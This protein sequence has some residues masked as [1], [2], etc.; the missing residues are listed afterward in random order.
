MRSLCGFV[1]LVLCA[2]FLYHAAGSLE[3]VDHDF[4][5]FPSVNMTLLFFSDQAVPA[6]LPKH[7]SVVENRALKIRPTAI[8][9]MPTARHFVFVVDNSGTMRHFQSLLK[10]MVHALSHLITRHDVYSCYLFSDQ[11]HTVCELAKQGDNRLERLEGLDFSGRKTY[12]YDSLYEILSH[13]LNYDNRVTVCLCLTD[14]IDEGSITTANDIVH[15]IN[16][17]NIKFIP[18]GFGAKQ[19]LDEL[20]RVS[21]ISGCQGFKLGDEQ[22]IM[23][24]TEYVTNRFSHFY[25]MLYL[26]RVT[27]PGPY[28]VS[29][30]VTAGDLSIHKTFKTAIPAALLPQ[31]SSAVAPAQTKAAPVKKARK[32][33]GSYLYYLFA[34]F[35]LIFAVVL[36]VLLSRRRQRNRAVA[37]PLEDDKIV[38]AEAEESRDVSAT[39]MMAAIPEL[40]DEVI[41]D[42]FDEDALGKTIVMS[43]EPV[44]TV[45]QGSSRKITYNLSGKEHFSIGR[46][47][48]NDIVLANRSVSAR[49]ALIRNISG[50]YVIY[51][52]KSTNGTF[53]NGQ[54]INKA[55]LKPGDSIHAGESIL[56]FQLRRQ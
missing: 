33:F 48:G 15:L 20:L 31:K 17:H 51:D 42:D 30:Q 16:T 5:A 44:I 52:L 7:V 4:S 37:L 32:S 24:L 9:R 19:S 8:T 38:T 26:S 43:E 29:I 50:A 46:A 18:L 14:G 11:P 40:T 21:R 1:C 27:A 3:V 6:L 2:H 13:R 25:R 39:T 12:I 28:D 55:L 23:L 10:A 41:E 53:V 54:R 34:L 47:E 22:D 56:V 35:F 36:F 49:H 45:K